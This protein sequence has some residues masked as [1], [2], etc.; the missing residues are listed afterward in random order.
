M[1]RIRS[2]DDFEPS[3]MYVNREL[4]WLAFA[5][6]VVA[7]VETRDL[8]LLERV[9]FAGISGMLHDEFFMKRMSG[10]KRQ[11]KKG[12]A[13]LSI[14]G[15]SFTAMISASPSRRIS[16]SSNK[17]C[18]YSARIAS[19]TRTSSIVSPMLMGR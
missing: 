15:R 14:D 1:A 9:K 17:P 2:L 8:P 13:K 18:V 4:S 10:L 3:K 6:R 19:R 16:M 12:S 7:L 5:G 11:I